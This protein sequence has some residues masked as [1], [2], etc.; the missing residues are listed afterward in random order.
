MLSLTYKSLYPA[1]SVIWDLFLWSWH[2]QWTDTDN[3][4][5]VWH[6]SHYKVTDKNNNVWFEGFDVHCIT[7]ITDWTTRLSVILVIMSVSTLK[8]TKYR[9]IALPCIIAE[10]SFRKN[11]YKYLGIKACRQAKANAEKIHKT[12]LN[13]FLVW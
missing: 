6:Q 4:R 9:Y 11:L 10:L 7:S 5:A 3:Y 2:F 1:L 8:C 12:F 13:G